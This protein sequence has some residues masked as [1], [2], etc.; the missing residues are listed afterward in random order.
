MKKKSKVLSLF[1]FIIIAPLCFIGVFMNMAKSNHYDLRF[2]ENILPIYDCD[3]IF[4]DSKR[5]LYVDSSEFCVIQVY[6]KDGKF[7]YR[8]DVPSSKGSFD[9]YIDDNDNLNIRTC[10]NDKEFIIKDKKVLSEQVE[11]K[12]VFDEKYKYYSEHK[13]YKYELS[14]TKNVLIYEGDNLLKE[15][16]LEKV[17]FPFSVFHYGLIMAL[18]LLFLF[19]CNKDWID[20]LA[21]KQLNRKDDYSKT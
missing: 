12:E 7:K 8:I 16:N 10:R 9:F 4:S 17:Y 2:S 20:K 21:Y 14:F 11:N 13:K 6:D 5:N 1:L 15:I 19:S 18:G 3:I